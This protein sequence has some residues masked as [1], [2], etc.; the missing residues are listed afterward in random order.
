MMDGLRDYFTT[1][2]IIIALAFGFTSGAKAQASSPP[3]APDSVISVSLLTA[4]PG[5]EIYQ[6]EGHSGLRIRTTRV[7]YVANWGIFD[8][9]QPNFIYRFVKGE[10]DY[11]VGL[12]PFSYFMSEYAYEHRR[13]LEQTLNLTPGQTQRLVTLVNEAVRPE[14]RTYRYNYVLDNCATRCIGI[15]E[16]ATGDSLHF[17]VAM[18]ELGDEVTFRSVMRRYH[19][20]YPWYQFGIDMALGSGID[21]P[22][23]V[24][25]TAFA[26]VVLSE[27][28]AHATIGDRKSVV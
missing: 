15:V 9:N 17:P 1:L 24:R 28:A 13:V 11:C 7:D 27:I 12:I 20:N 18:A 2:L 16:E 10:T 5:S 6:L 14:S 23:S 3:A 25:Q 19:R 4:A 26:P 22:L 8:F 21:Y